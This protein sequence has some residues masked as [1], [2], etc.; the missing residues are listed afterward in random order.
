[1]VDK[2]GLTGRQLG[3]RAYEV[4]AGKANRRP[5]GADA[6][7][8]KRS[9]AVHD[10]TVIS[11]AARAQL[12]KATSGPERPDKPARPKQSVKRTTAQDQP[13]RRS[14][15]PTLRPWA[16][17]ELAVKPDPIQEPVGGAKTSPRITPTPEKPASQHD[18][19]EESPAAPH[20]P[21]GR[22]NRLA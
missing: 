9:D 17:P 15:A 12:R 3:L 19:P 21:G 22:F 2:V 7:I 11:R 13:R 10:T 16:P 5:Q 6:T 18:A 8:A 14:Q 1:M 20:R 4:A